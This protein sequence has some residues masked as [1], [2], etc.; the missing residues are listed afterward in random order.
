LSRTFP[1]GI[2]IAVAASGRRRHHDQLRHARQQ[3][4]ASD[5]VREY[6]HRRAVEHQGHYDQTMKIYPE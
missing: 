2:A 3:K 4:A 6:C 5:P 1:I